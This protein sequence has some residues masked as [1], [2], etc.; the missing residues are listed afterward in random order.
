MTVVRQLV[1][2]AMFFFDFNYDSVTLVQDMEKIKT[3]VSWRERC[4]N[5][6]LQQNK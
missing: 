1:G 5:Q 2:C 6:F 4:W 3:V